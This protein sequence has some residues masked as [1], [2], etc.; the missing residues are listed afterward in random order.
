MAA[1]QRLSLAGVRSPSLA[2]VAVSIS[3]GLMF[4]LAYV[5]NIWQDEAYTLQTTS[6]GIVYAF[7]QAVAFEQSAPLYFLAL[8]LWRHIN[9]SVFFL[10]LFSVLCA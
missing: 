3:V 5:L 6:R 10:R 9:D 7:H 4:V 2:T 8:T 1:T